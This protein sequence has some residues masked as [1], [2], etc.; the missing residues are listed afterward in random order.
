MRTCVGARS[1]SRR[2]PFLNWSGKLFVGRAEETEAHIA[3]ALRLSPRD[4]LAYRWMNMAGL[5]KDLLGNWEQAVA[6][7]GRSI[8]ANRN[9]P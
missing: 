2:G 9:T 3:K 7:F 8:E 5:A 4:T 1:K 6:W